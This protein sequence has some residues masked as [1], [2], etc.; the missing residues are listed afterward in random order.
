MP[1]QQW[2]HHP[3]GASVLSGFRF[4]QVLPGPWG[5]GGITTSSFHP[6]SLGAWLPGAANLWVVFPSS[7][8]LLSF[9]GT[10]VTN[11][12]NYIPSDLNGV[13]P[14]SQLDFKLYF[15]DRKLYTQAWYLEPTQFCR[16]NKGMATTGGRGLGHFPAHQILVKHPLG[17]GNCAGHRN[18]VWTKTHYF[19]SP[20]DNNITVELL[21]NSQLP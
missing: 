15:Q 19:R 6:S 9:P 20:T 5:G 7:F 8:Y 14:L 2:L 18:L 12:L 10:Y 21:Y 1:P 13:A 11:F 17:I 16:Y 3:L 4:T